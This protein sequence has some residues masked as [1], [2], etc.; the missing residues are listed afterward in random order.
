MKRGFICLLCVLLVACSQAKILDD[1]YLVQIMGFDYLGNRTLKGMFVVSLYRKENRVQ[2]KVFSATGKTGKEAKEKADLKSALPLETGQVRVILFSEAFA[3]HGIQ[4][5]V[6]TLDRIPKVGNLAYPAVTGGDLQKI[7]SK[8]YDEEEG[9]VEGLSSLFEQEIKT[10]TVPRSNLYLLSNSLY[11]DARD[12]FLPYIM[13]GKDSIRIAGIALFY[14][15]RMRDILPAKN[16]FIFKALID[17]FSNGAYSFRFKNQFTVIENINAK[18]DYKVQ[19]SSVLH[20]NMKVK[21][22]IQEFTEEKNL[23]VPKLVRQIEK[24]ME[25]SAKKEVE[26]LILRFQEKGV[27]PLGLGRVYRAKDRN[28]NEKKWRSDYANLKVK[29]HVQVKVV[30]SGV[31]E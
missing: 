2:T 31:V 1:L 29:V 30:Q 20:I 6:N 17:G 9:V 27:D 12:A 14:K 7:L 18:T 26:Q 25:Q 22:K 13:Q 23:E 11:D 5:I 4:E 21:G 19:N 24:E 10:G 15:D 16:M 8:E 28:W 3:R